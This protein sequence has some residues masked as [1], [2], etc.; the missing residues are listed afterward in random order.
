[1]SLLFKKA[2]IG[3]ERFLLAV[4][5]EI[6]SARRVARIPPGYDVSVSHDPLIGLHEGVFTRKLIISF[7]GGNY[8]DLVYNWARYQ[9]VSG[10]PDTVPNAFMRLPL[11]EATAEEARRCLE[12]NSRKPWLKSFGTI[13]FGSGS[14]SGNEEP[15][16]PRNDSSPPVNQG[17]APR[18]PESTDLHTPPAA[19]SRAWLVWLAT[20]AAVIGGAWLLF[21]LVRSR[22][23]SGMK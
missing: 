23:G 20:A 7:S 6:S 3:E 16:P 19:A 13:P 14:F 8:E 5:P 11:I 9:I 2:V 21:M 10:H 17:D 12:E 1:M 22:S 18:T 15:R 4:M